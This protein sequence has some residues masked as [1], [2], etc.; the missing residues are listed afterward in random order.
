MRFDGLFVATVK[1]TFFWDVMPYD[2]FF[3]FSELH[4]ATVKMEAAS[5]FETDN[6]L[7]NCMASH[8]RRHSSLALY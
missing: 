5:C 4:A 1:M 2:F 7:P 3:I 8:F 6:D